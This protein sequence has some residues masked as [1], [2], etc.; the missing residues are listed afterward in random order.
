MKKTRLAINELCF[1]TK[2]TSPALATHPGEFPFVVTAAFRR[3]ANHWQLNGP[4]VCIPLISSTGHG[5]AA[6]HRIHYQEGKFALSN[7][8]VALT[9]R[10]SYEYNSKYLWYYLSIHK[11]RLLVPLMAGTANVSLKIG[12]IRNVEVEL[13]PLNEQNQIIERIERAIVRIEQCVA[14]AKSAIADQTTLL[15][16]SFKDS[17]LTASRVKMKVLAPLVRRAVTVD[18]TRSYPELGIRSFGKGTFHK[19][20]INGSEIG[21]KKLF[22]IQPGD[23]IFNIVFAWEGAVAIAEDRDTDR[24]GSHRFLTCVVNEDIAM[25]PFVHY[26][27][28]TDIGLSELDKASPGG[29]G[30]NR[31]LS[32]NG[33]ANIEVPIPSKTKQA[34]FCKALSRIRSAQSLQEAA[35]QDMEQLCTTAVAASL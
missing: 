29:A 18:P 6:I 2:G 22:L 20:S 10:G 23:L 15:Q 3:S 9:P 1:L 8:L 19:P 5:D 14:D 33:L 16:Q 17:I 24:F 12:D 4:A 30:R 32:L 28:L 21:N 26:F 25:T 31:T 34:E 35:I 11:D 7:L 27:F 13:P